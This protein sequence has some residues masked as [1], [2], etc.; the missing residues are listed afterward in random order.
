MFFLYSISLFNAK[1]IS[2]PAQ[3]TAKKS[4]GGVSPVSTSDFDPDSNIIETKEKTAAKI[5]FPWKNFF[6]TN[7]RGKKIAPTL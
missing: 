3:I 7:I 4:N 5:N 6:L 1:N 2:I